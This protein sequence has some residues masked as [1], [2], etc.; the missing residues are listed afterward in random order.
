M[1]RGP[2]EIRDFLE[3]AEQAFLARAKEAPA[4]VMLRKAF[5]VLRQVRTVVTGRGA[6]LPACQHLASACDPARFTEPDLAAVARSFS[7]LESSLT[8]Y[9]RTGTMV[10]A[11]DGFADGHANAVIVGPGGLVKRSGVQIGVTLMAPGIRYPDHTH[12]PEET[13]L[14]M[15]EGAFGHGAS[16]WIEPGIGGTF[17]NPPGIVHRMRAGCVPLWAFWVLRS[18]HD[19][20]G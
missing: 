19:A 12:P 7:V 17:Y 2:I 3:A 4:R 8:W 14:V 1:Q 9:R 16:S 11:G 13:Y 20:P 10:A 6:R 15:S 5:E 18:E